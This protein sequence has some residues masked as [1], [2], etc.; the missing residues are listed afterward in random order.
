MIT[1]KLPYKA[2]Q[3]DIDIINQYQKDYSSLVRSIY[4]HKLKGKSDIETRLYSKSIKQLNCWFAESALY[5]VKTVIKNNKENI[6]FGSKKQF[7]RRCKGL[8]TNEQ[9][10]ESR[11]LPIYS[12]GQTNQFGNRLFR[13]NILENNQIIFKPN[14]KTKIELNLPQLKPNIKKQLIEVEKYS[15]NKE[16]PF[17]IRLNKTHIY[18]IF[19]P[20]V[21]TV[22]KL[23][24]KERYLSIDLNPNHIGLNIS[25]YKN[26]KYEIK[27]TKH[28]DLTELVKHNNSN[29]IKF[30]SIEICKS[31][32]NL[33]K[34]FKCKYMFIEDLVMVGKNHDKG[35]NLNKLINN[36]WFRNL[37]S[38]NLEKRCKLD[39]ILFYKVNPAYTTIIGNLSYEYSDPVNASLEIGR[40]GY[41]YNILK[42]KDGFY[43]EFKLKESLQHLWKEMGNDLFKEW[44][45]LFLFIKNSKMRYRVP[46]ND[47][48][49]CHLVYRYEYSKPRGLFEYVFK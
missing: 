25:E 19:E 42:N 8:I 49:K 47:V 37:V 11:I 10:R 14:S 29:K 17:T 13:L 27:Y 12:V 48:E 5:D 35:K 31:I 20:I 30:E 39:N 21:N 38:N 23:D 36:S 22:P 6:I 18:I 2:N 44:K 16:I 7:I 46:I 34:H 45:E 26:N 43:P 32:I 40:R 41:E 4:N 24:S 9:Y 3:N 33:T 1:I 28:I 15:K